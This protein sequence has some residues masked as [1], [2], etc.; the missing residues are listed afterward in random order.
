[1]S[2]FDKVSNDI[3]NAIGKLDYEDSE[4]KVMQSQILYNIYNLL[5]SEECYESSIKTLVK[6]EA[7]E[8][9]ER[10][11]RLILSNNEQ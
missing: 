8:K 11:N 1:M 9:R 5:K 2:T 3:I 7:A 4:S 10:I 6:K